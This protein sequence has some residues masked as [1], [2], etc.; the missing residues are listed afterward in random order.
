MVEQEPIPTEP[1]IKFD[2]GEQKAIIKVNGVEVEAHLTN[3]TP[4]EVCEFANW[5]LERARDKVTKS[6]PNYAT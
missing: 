3:A 1:P 2:M 5:L 4:K 6:N